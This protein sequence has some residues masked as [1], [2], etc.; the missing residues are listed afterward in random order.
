LAHLH[1]TENSRQSEKFTKKTDRQ[2]TLVLRATLP[3]SRVVPLGRVNTQPEPNLQRQQ[4]S[5]PIPKVKSPGHYP[6][7]VLTQYSQTA[8]CFG[9]S[10]VESTRWM[11][12]GQPVKL[13]AL[14]GHVKYFGVARHPGRTT[15]YRVTSTKSRLSGKVDRLEAD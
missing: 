3:V 4:R 13:A 10:I 14:I 2:R 11:I 5:T 1:P 9:V 8:E 15:V 12:L 7:Q 6:S